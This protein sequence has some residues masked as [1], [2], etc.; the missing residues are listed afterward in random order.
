MERFRVN[1]EYGLYY[2]TFTVVQWLP[3]F[4]SEAACR[5]VADSLNYCH[6]HKRLRINAFVIMPTH[7][8]M[9]LFD[10]EGNN[11]RLQ[12]TLADFRKFTGRRLADF[13]A[14][15]LPRCFT[16]VM[17]K[18]AGGDRE[19]RFWQPTRHPEP[20]YS[21]SFWRQKLD[22]L[23]DNPRRKGLVRQ[24]DHWRF[25]SAGYWL[26]E[27]VKESDVILTAVEW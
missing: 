23:H 8:H 16:E 9:I 5:I 26:R 4:T 7:M 27:R 11:D 3:V 14:E 20:I 22:Y 25:S 10:A 13:T 15:H 6:N 1:E 18:E 19:R 24:A 17:E 21:A 2:V 12:H